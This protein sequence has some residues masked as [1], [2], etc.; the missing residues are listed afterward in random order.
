VL[1]D[2]AGRP[3]SNVRDL[4]PEADYAMR[5]ELLAVDDRIV[6]LFWDKSGREPGVKVR[7]L[8]AS[9]RIGGMSIGVGVAKVRSLLAGDR[10]LAGWQ[11]FL[12]RLAG[13]PG[14]QR[15]RSVSPTPR[16]RARAPRA[17]DPGDRVRPRQGQE[18]R[19]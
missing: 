11:R 15:G 6:L 19:K 12:G 5:P 13:E 14:Q 16:R 2:A 4:T 17:R 9:G 1:V 10:P 7:W 3:A 18:A 8:D